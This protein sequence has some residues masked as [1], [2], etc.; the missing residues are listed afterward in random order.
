MS[1]EKTYICNVCQR[2]ATMLSD[3]VPSGWKEVEIRISDDLD[4]VM[5]RIKKLRGHFC[6]HCV[7]RYRSDPKGLWQKTQ[8]L[9]GFMSAMAI[10]GGSMDS[11]VHLHMMREE[12]CN[13]TNT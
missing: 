9:L 4:D 8:N 3:Q 7:V 10:I 12:A 5:T 2:K 6:D 13:T 11:L 1:I